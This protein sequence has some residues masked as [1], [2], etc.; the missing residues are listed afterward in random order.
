MSQKIHWYVPVP[1]PASPAS[2][3]FLERR[4]GRAQGAGPCGPGVARDG[5]RHAGDQQQGRREV[6]VVERLSLEGAPH[7][8]DD[9]H[10]R[11]DGRD[12]EEHLVTVFLRQLA[13][14]PVTGLRLHEEE[15]GGDHQDGGDRDAQGRDDVGPLL[16]RLELRE[17]LRELRRD[18]RDEQRVEAGEV[19][20][21]VLERL[22]AVRHEAHG[23]PD[24]AADE[25]VPHRAQV[26]GADGALDGVETEGE[27][28]A[29]EAGEQ[30][31][32]ERDEHRA[33]VAVR[34]VR[35]VAGHPKP[36]AVA[37]SPCS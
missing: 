21:V 4:R 16:L 30:E 10:D 26:V 6:D 5:G 23:D 29:D 13:V 18:E 20:G 2:L 14:R 34:L 7:E 17:G 19:E 9:E 11:E 1:S 8:Q 22:T 33:Q 28:R 36:G 12:P 35:E 3:R 25:D 31:H 24:H 27:R 37:S 32:G 15:R